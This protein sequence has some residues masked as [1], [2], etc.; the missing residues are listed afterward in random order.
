MSLTLKQT[1]PSALVASRA[2]ILA[3]SVTIIITVVFTAFTLATSYFGLKLLLIPLGLVVWFLMT[4]FPEI[5]LGCLMVVG[6][7]KGASQLEGSLIDLT[8]VLVLVLVWSMGRAFSNKSSI[9]LPREFL[10]YV[11]LLFM[12]LLS[13]LYTPDLSGGIDKTARFFIICGVAILG[14]FA[15]LTTP[16]RL[17]RFFWTLLMA[18]MIASAM[19]LPML[20]GRERLTAP[21]GDTIQL[22]H[23]AAVGIAIVWFGLM[24]GRKLL[25]R[26]ILYGCIAVLAVALVG[27][28]S[29]GPIIALGTVILISI[30]HRRRVGFTVPQLLFDFAFIFGI[31]ILFLPFVHIPEESTDYLGRLLSFKSTAAYMG[32]RAGLLQFGWK[33]TLAHPIT[34]VGIGGFPVLYTGIGNWPHSIPLEIGSELGLLAALSFCCLLFLAL[35][36]ALKEF[37]SGDDDSQTIRNL[38]FCFIVIVTVGMLNTGNLNDNRQLWTALSLPFLFRSARVAGTPG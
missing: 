10:F 22:G 18:G 7:F 32:P 33:L 25:V 31:G 30:W 27:S 21:G 14:P 19:S 4:K 34:G 36:T 38:M 9:V 23:V 12:M 8:V 37:L 20:G 17:K 24:P 29:R 15:V 16:A 26:L 11:P 35:K 2:H 6:T 28:G 5:A 3:S 13:L 1:H